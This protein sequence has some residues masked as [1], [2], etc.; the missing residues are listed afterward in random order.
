MPMV[1]EH[2]ADHGLSELGRGAVGDGAFN[3][4]PV[5]AKVPVT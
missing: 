5:T 2:S 4:I 3:G 1:R